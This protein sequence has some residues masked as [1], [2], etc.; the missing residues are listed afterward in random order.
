MSRI[1]RVM[2][3]VAVAVIGASCA[4]SPYDGQQFSDGKIPFAGF[5]DEPNAEIRFSVRDRTNNS[6]PLVDSVRSS[7]TPT[8]AAGAFCSNSPA[9]FK[10]QKTVWPLWSL[11]WTQ[12]PGGYETKVKAR[13]YGSVSER[14]ILFT[15]N[16]NGVDCILRNI[17]PGCDFMTVAVTLCGYSRYE[18]TVKTTSSRPW[19]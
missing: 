4:T 15:A 16:P 1:H 9:L 19:L 8:F 5:V 7:A 6:F 18:A 3:I 14:D 2:M 11:F 17:T 12:I 10:Y 13:K